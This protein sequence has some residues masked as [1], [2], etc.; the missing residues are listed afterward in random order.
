MSD[1]FMM[2]EFDTMHHIMKMIEYAD[3][4]SVDEVHDFCIEICKYHDERMKKGGRSVERGEYTA[5]DLFLYHLSFVLACRHK[6]KCPYKDDDMLLS[7]GTTISRYDIFD[8]NIEPLDREML[9]SDGTLSKDADGN[10]VYDSSKAEYISED[11]KHTL[12]NASAL[13]FGEKHIN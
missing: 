7:D 12:C 13:R 11:C 2:H 4:M 1:N 9:F 3:S 8:C 10:T 5:S 6:Y